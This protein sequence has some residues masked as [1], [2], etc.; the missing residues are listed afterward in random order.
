[1]LRLDRGP[2]RFRSLNSYRTDDGGVGDS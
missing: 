1:V 2:V